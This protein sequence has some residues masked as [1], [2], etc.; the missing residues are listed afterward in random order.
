VIVSPPR[1]ESWDELSGVLGHAPFIDRSKGE[2][3][4]LNGS[5][6]FLLLSRSPLQPDEEDREG[7]AI[8]LVKCTDEH[9]L[10]G[11]FDTII[12]GIK[13]DNWQYIIDNYLL[14]EP[15]EE[16]EG[17]RGWLR[18]LNGVVELKPNFFGLGVNLNAALEEI[19]KKYLSPTQSRSSK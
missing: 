18:L 4:F 8:N 1:G 2:D 7:L 6:P 13:K 3:E 14:Q 9:E 17:C 16:P 5:M 10:A 12:T 19:G 11:V 15:A